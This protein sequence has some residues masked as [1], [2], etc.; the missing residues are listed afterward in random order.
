MIY[1]ICFLSSAFFAYLA[2]RAKNKDMIILYSVISILIPSIL[3]GLRA[4]GVGWDT[5]T[6]GRSH[7]NQALMALSFEEFTSTNGA[8]LG[9]NFLCY[10]IMK[11]L[12]HEN[13][14]YFFFI[15]IPVTCIYIGAW[16]H[17]DKIWM[18]LTILVFYFMFYNRYLS[19]IRQSVA[20]GIVFMN[21]D[22]LEKKEYLKFSFWVCIASLFHRSAFM[23][24]GVGLGLYLIVTSEAMRKSMTFRLFVM[25]SMAVSLMFAR[26][27]IFNV[28]S[29]IP[30]LATRYS[31]VFNSESFFFSVETHYPVTLTMIA[32]I[33][34]MTLYRNG[35]TKALSGPLENRN[36]IEFYKFN[37]IF[38]VIFQIFVKFYLSRVLMYSE[39]L[40]VYAVAAIPS[41]IKEKYLKYATIACV[42]LFA[43]AIWYVRC[44][45]RGGNSGTY[46]Y[47][48]IVPIL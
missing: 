23:V 22:K 13:W 46:P 43:M 20:L 27:L 18:P 26:I 7:C 3:G 29:I 34:M 4:Y 10:F 38:C 24:Y 11:T 42:V 47:R 19:A 44:M 33:I 45:S 2:D 21:F 9:Y 25:A 37:I 40:N 28:I 14:Y 17:R 12:G 36:N 48:S 41:F 35:A 31:S 5:E 6:Y 15:L 39:L 16:R 30:I 1:V 32:T 8:D